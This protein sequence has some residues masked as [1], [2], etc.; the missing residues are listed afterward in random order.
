VVV[1]PAAADAVPDAV[2]DAVADALE[3]PLA[4]GDEVLTVELEPTIEEK[5]G[6]ATDG[7]GAPAGEV[8]TAG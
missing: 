7:A 8:A 4:L 1:A 3:E 5:P 2:P 6:A